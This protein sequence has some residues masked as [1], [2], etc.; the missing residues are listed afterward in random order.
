MEIKTK[1]K[2]KMRRGRKRKGDK[3]KNMILLMDEEI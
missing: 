1:K 3:L 2:I